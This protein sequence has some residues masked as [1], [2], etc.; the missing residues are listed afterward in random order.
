MT[1]F[2]FAVFG[3]YMMMVIVQTN[4]FFEVVLC[5]ALFCWYFKR[6][7]YFAPRLVGGLIGMYVVTFI[8][9]VIRTECD[10][11]A[12]QFL[13]SF[14]IFGA[15]LGVLFLCFSEKISEI[16]LCWC[17]GLATLQATA[18]I[19]G[20]IFAS[21][22]IDDHVSISF[23][24]TSNAISV[25]DWLIYYAMHLSLYVAMS[26]IFS[27]KKLRGNADS[28]KNT[29]I[30]SVFTVV[31]M[32]VMSPWIRYYEPTDL[33]ARCI[34]KILMALLFLLVLVLRTGIFTVS[35]QKQDLKI[36]NELLREEKK[37]FER[38]KSNID[39]IN[40]KCHDLKHH[41]SDLEGKISSAELA[42]L[43][44]A[45]EI[46]DTSLKTGNDILDVVIYEKSLV[47][48]RENIRLTCLADGGALSFMSAAHIYSLIGNALDNAIE[49]SLAVEQELRAIGLTVT[50]NHGL[51]EITVVNR[52]V[53]ERDLAG[54]A[55]ATSK[56]DSA[57]HGYGVKSMKY[58][59]AQ[60]DGKLTLS[61]ENGIFTVRALIPPPC[62][63]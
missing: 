57:R 16:L 54:D 48:E 1:E 10:V 27:R 40:M 38:V 3:K 11:L 47:C 50:H 36:M 41:L 53:G 15:M 58:I 6:R 28:M 12:M 24:H 60:Y 13:S 43:K 32:T 35:K 37:Q 63:I 20:I 5:T 42:E 51:I 21:C 23:F 33:T 44:S 45:I 34:V 55:V 56:A 46:Y 22:G 52:F 9:A 2:L 29:I 61:A 18:A 31:F 26:F 17:G 30:M 49:A 8:A 4:F 7:K 59:A 14:M 39:I 19:V 25:G 62:D